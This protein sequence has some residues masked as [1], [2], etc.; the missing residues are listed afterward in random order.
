LG[1]RGLLPIHVEPTI[2]NYHRKRAETALSVLDSNLAHR[3][4]L[5]FRAN[6]RGYIL[7]RR[8]S[9]CGNLRVR[10]APLDERDW[11]DRTDDSAARVSGTFRIVGDEG[12]RGVLASPVAERHRRARSVAWVWTALIV[13]IM[14]SGFETLAV[15]RKAFEILYCQSV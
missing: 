5:C 8:H 1:Q 2:A 9:L 10:L 14:D 6:Y 4:Y 13:A 11:V 12:C 3:N 15:C 7:L